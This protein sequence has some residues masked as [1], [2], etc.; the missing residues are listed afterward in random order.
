MKKLIIFCFLSLSF[1]NISFASYDMNTMDS[2]YANVKGIYSKLIDIW[3]ISKEEGNNLINNA[4]FRIYDLGNNP[5]DVYNNALEYEKRQ[6]EIQNLYLNLKNEQNETYWKIKD[7][8]YKLENNWYLNNEE[9]N[10]LLTTYYADI[11]T[12]FKTTN[13]VYNNYLTLEKQQLNK[14]SELL[15]KETYWKIKDGLNNLFTKW[16]ISEEKYTWYLNYFNSNIFTYPQELSLVFSEYI[17]LSKNLIQ[18]N[19]NFSKVN[20]ISNQYYNKY[21]NQLWNRLSW[22]SLIKLDSVTLKIEKL[23]KI[24]NKNSK[25][26]LQLD[27]L[28]AIIKEEINIKIMQE[29]EEINLD[30]IL[31]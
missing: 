6:W 27:A 16:F 25:M 31:Q 23:K 29:N 12:S 19:I 24:Y 14:D 30:N 18:E 13:E 1:I 3:Y 7:G 22:F 15:K 8:L 21:K 20:N 26:Y 28:G 9:V 17:E 11:F 5:E 10:E 2:N 4:Y